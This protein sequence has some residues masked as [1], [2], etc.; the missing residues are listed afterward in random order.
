M[1]DVAPQLGLVALLVIISGALSGSELA[2][3]SLRE[4]QLRRLDERGGVGRVVATLARDPNR[5]LA[6]I[7]IGITGSGFLASAAAA[8]SLADPL[9]EHLGVFGDSA[10]AVAVVSVTLLL[11]Y[12]TLVVGELVPKRLALQ[13]AEGWSL[14][15]ARPLAVFSTLARPVVWTLS[16]STNAVVRLLGGDPRVHREAVTREEIRELVAMQPGFSAQQRAII[17]GAFEVA[18]RTLREILVP[19]GEV[20]TVAADLSADDALAALIESGYS[21]APVVGS[22][23]LDGAVGMVHMRQLVGGVEGTA[24]DLAIELP[25]LPE[26]LAVVEALRHLQEQR[27][28]MALVLDEHGGAQGIVTTKDV[29]EEVVGEIYDELD[30]DVLSAQRQPDGSLVLPGRYPIHDLEDLGLDLPAGAYATV[31]GFVLDRLGRA[32]RAPGDV[33]TEG[34]LVITVTQVRG[35]SVSEVRIRQR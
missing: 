9:A 18:S 23:G 32:P 8:V 33:I 11:T 31:A 35:H 20:F 21:R 22:D 27:I 14:V 3:V 7:E 10:R 2:L 34:D 12:V 15:A 4:G 25:A 17:D 30:R 13:R 26:T 5:Y 6:T 29:I 16:V 1:G 19:R 24:Q 28:S